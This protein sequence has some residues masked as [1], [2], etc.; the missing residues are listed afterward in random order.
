MSFRVVNFTVCAGQNAFCDG[1]DSRQLHNKIAGQDRKSWHVFF[2][3]ITPAGRMMIGALRSL[4]EHEREL[5]RERT[6]LKR[7]ASRANGA[8]FGRRYL[9]DS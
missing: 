7:Q 4:A 5:I 9:T 8:K 3:V 1:F 2:P 6:T